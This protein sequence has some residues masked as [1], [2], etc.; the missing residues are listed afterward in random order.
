MFAEQSQDGSGGSGN[1]GAGDI[2]WTEFAPRPVPVKPISTGYAAEQ[3]VVLIP[4]PVV[5]QSPVVAA[6]AASSAALDSSAALMPPQMKRP[7][8]EDEAPRFLARLGPYS[9]DYPCRGLTNE[10]YESL[11][12]KDRGDQT[13]IPLFFF[14]DR[15]MYGFHPPHPFLF[16][17]FFSQEK[18]QHTTLSSPSTV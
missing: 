4:V 10:E 7:H 18:Q 16:L 6:A 11:P 13:S 15:L 8:R 1:S 9:S 17:S 2:S 14:S 5:T 3:R 12:L